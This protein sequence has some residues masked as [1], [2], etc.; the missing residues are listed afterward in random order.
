[1]AEPRFD[2]IAPHSERYKRHSEGAITIL[3]DGQFLLGWSAFYGGFH[4]PS[5]AHILAMRSD[6]GGET[7]SEPVVILE[8]DGKCNVMNVCF[9]QPGDGSIVM[10]HVR[11]DDETCHYSWPFSRKS[12]DGGHTWTA[13][14]PMVD[15]ETWLG[16]PANDRMIVHSSGRLITP[17]SIQTVR[18]NPEDG[19]G[20]LQPVRSD[21][22]GETW[23]LS[24]NVS[25]VK[26]PDHPGASEPVVV[27]RKDGSL[28]FFNRT[29]L[30]TIW[31]AE[32]HDRGETVSEP[33]D[34]GIQCPAAPCIVKRI[35]S[36]GDLLLIWNNAK[37]DRPGSG[38]PRMPLTTAIS[39]DDGETWN[40]VKDLEPD[41]SRSYMYPSLTFVGDTALILYSQGE[42]DSVVKW[43]TNWHNT[44]LKLARVP[45]EWFYEKPGGM[46][47]LP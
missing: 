22:M 26:D 25:A 5:P 15:M 46:N 33:W 34:T 19:R 40:N 23:Q 17:M 27:E 7:W 41:L 21:D 18:P 20:L 13:H 47:C 6:D 37:P 8:N 39:R 29:R 4:D 16:C 11:T 35:P 32:S 36:T 31:A 1:M 12:T 38:G 43:S 10:S 14:K 42:A 24:S 2:I 45:V 3:P 30:G 28:L 44:S 9:A